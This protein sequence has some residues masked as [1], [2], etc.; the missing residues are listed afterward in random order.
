MY[1]QAFKAIAKE[2]E[3]SNNSVTNLI[4]IG[5]TIK[6]SC[7]K[8]G[9]MEA[10]QSIDDANVNKVVEQVNVFSSLFNLPEGISFEKKKETVLEMIGCIKKYPSIDFNLHFKKAFDDYYVKFQK[11]VDGINKK[12]ILSKVEE[13]STLFTLLENISIMSEINN[14][15]VVTVTENDKVIKNYSSLNKKLYE[16]GIVVFKLQFKDSSECEIVARYL[17]E[18]KQIYFF[19]RAL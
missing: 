16:K 6:D 11:D 14:D 9:V 7:E 17:E 19:A 13:F 15:S 10:A 8:N 5:I 18:S 2:I 4:E 1:G 3:D 12:L